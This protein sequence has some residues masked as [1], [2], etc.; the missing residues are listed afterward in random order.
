MQL[1][2]KHTH[3]QTVALEMV[4]YVAKNKETNEI[5]DK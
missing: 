5:V 3:R 2:R 4:F 1:T